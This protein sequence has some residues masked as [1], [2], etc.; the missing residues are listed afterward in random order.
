M[1]FLILPQAT[2]MEKQC[3][4]CGEVKPLTGYSIEARAKDGRRAA[5]KPCLSRQQNL[6]NRNHPAE[7]VA[8]ERRRKLIA[9]Y[10]ITLEEWEAMWVEQGGRCK[11]CGIEEKYVPKGRFHTDHCHDSG[12]VRGLLCGH[13]NKGLGMFKDNEEFLLS[14]INY[15]QETR[16]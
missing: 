3:T 2:D 9:V 6:Y 8:E 13:C 5:C 1:R 16:E 10:G 12:K 14:A 11:I 15:L 4:K 7:Y